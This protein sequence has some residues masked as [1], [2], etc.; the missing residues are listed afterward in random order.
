VGFAN[1]ALYWM[2][3]NASTLPARPFH[4]VT[5]G[6]NLAYDAGSGWDFATGWGSMDGA[7]LAAAWVLYI[8]GGGS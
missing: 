5:T 6:N 2:G 3:Q 8:K 7:A 1:P 4:D